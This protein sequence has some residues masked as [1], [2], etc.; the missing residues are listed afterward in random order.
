[1][2]WRLHGFIFVFL[3]RI[4]V[5]VVSAVVSRLRNAIQNWL[6][7]RN[8]L[9]RSHGCFSLENTDVERMESR[10]LFL[11]H[12]GKSTVDGKSKVAGAAPAIYE[13]QPVRWGLGIHAACS[14]PHTST[15]RPGSLK[16]DRFFR[17]SRKNCSVHV[18]V[19][20]GWRHVESLNFGAKARSYCTA[21]VGYYMAS[22]S[23]LPF[24][25]RLFLTAIR[26]SSD[27]TPSEEERLS[28]FLIHRR[29]L[30]NYFHPLMF[31]V[32]FWCSWLMNPLCL[33][34]LLAGVG[35]I[36]LGP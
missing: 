13:M 27:Y 25:G 14:T 21:R 15:R 4:V 35:M 6:L 36:C 28:T 2:R 18:K 8:I 31:G 3:V 23:P 24:A 34:C 20:N 32:L 30:I 1:M 9:R 29:T 10:D 7:Q 33:V 11:T 19:A 22:V 16:A 17:A 5:S 12:S 26:R